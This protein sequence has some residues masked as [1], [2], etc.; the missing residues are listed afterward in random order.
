L[1]EIEKKKDMMHETMGPICMP[2]LI[3]V[4]DFQGLVGVLG[5]PGMTQQFSAVIISS[6]A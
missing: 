2:N 4:I 3:V 5:F 6:S 1:T